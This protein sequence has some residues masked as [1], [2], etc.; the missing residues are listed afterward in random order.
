MIFDIELFDGYDVR[1]FVIN[2]LYANLSVQYIGK[3]SY[4]GLADFILYI[5]VL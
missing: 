1:N 2:A 3:S 5:A 4:D